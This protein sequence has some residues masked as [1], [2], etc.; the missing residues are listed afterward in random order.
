M[1]TPKK[2]R[3]LARSLV[4]READSSAASLQTEPASVRVYERLRR[5]LGAPVGTE[6]FQ[7]LAT[8]ALALARSESPRLNAVQV[9]ANG[10]LRG[11]GEIE[12][13]T[14]SGEDGDVGII[15]IAQLL[16][17][18][19]TLLGESTTMRLI[20][21]LRLQAEIETES[22]ATST[23]TAD[24]VSED[25]AIAA[26]FEDLLLEI[27]QLRKVS[28][29]IENL[30]DKHPGM[31]EGLLSTAGSIRS[32]ATVLDVFTLI[33]SKA[34]GPQEDAPDLQTNRYMN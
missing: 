21:D 26:A 31:E 33:R 23:G 16:G 22:V 13:Q 25:L 15:L 19:L 11:L 5:Q 7:S 12:S 28:A 9:M 4:A 32:I 29:R 27:D 34:G 24:L 8:R 3:D 30:A 2:T 10:G 20:E 17:L 1:L 18:F 6:G 14:N